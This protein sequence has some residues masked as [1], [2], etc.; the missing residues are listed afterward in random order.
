MLLKEIFFFNKKIHNQL[1]NLNI[2]QNIKIKKIKYT[3]TPWNTCHIYSHTRKV[4]YSY[5][6]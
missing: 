1:T 3:F 4:T 5:N 6:T 2:F